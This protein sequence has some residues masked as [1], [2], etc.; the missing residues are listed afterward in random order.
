MIHDI[1]FEVIIIYFNFSKTHV[2]NNAWCR[3]EV[4]KHA[5]SHNTGVVSSIPPCVTFK[6]PLVRRATG[7]YLM[8][9]TSLEKTQSPVSCF[10][11]ARNRVC[12]AVEQWADFGVA[13]I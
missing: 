12:N 6:K 7:N 10:C 8:N 9:S 4:V 11:Y 2:L 5:D 13:D 1:E 3:G